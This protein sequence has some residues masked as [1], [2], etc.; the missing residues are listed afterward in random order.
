[1]F[2][3][4]RVSVSIWLPANAIMDSIS[5]SKLAFGVPITIPS[6]RNGKGPLNWLSNAVM[7]GCMSMIAR[8][9]GAAPR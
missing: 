6:E 8:F 9:F 7:S 2:S 3:W 5:S 4:Y 1:M